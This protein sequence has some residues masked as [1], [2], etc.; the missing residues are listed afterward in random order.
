VRTNGCGQ[1]SVTPQFVQ[2]VVGCIYKIARLVGFL[3]GTNC[4]DGFGGGSVGGNELLRQWAV[5]KK[6]FQ[7]SSSEAPLGDFTGGRFLANSE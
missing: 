3:L 6:L 2:Q 5:A 7:S 1:R 4:Q